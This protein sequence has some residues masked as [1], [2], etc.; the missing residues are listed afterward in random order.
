MDNVRRGVIIIHMAGSH[1]RMGP[2]LMR[3]VNLRPGLSE[4]ALVRKQMIRRGPSSE[5][6]AQGL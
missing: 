3:E 4:L 6:D 1:M 2:G 5:P